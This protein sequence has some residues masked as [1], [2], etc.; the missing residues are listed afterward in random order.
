[1]QRSG[2]SREGVSFAREDDFEVS[3]VSLMSIHDARHK[4]TDLKV[5]VVVI[6][7]EGWARVAIP[8]LVGHRLFII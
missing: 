8:L 7:K 5:F 3:F 6:P 1:M 4:K 2:G